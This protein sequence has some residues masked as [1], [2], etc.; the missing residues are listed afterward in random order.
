MLALIFQTALGQVWQN[1]IYNSA[2]I[3][4][5]CATLFSPSREIKEAAILIDGAKIRVVAPA[6]TLS[7]PKGAQ[8]VDAGALIAAPGLIDW[9]LNGGFGHDF[10]ENPASIWDVAARLPEHGVTSFL[11]TVIT[12]PLEKYA[13][14]QE[15]LRNGPPANFLGAQPLGLH[16][17]GPYLNPVRKGAHNALF[18]RAPSL[19]E[20]ENWS[21]KEGVW[22]VTLAPELPGAH[23]LIGSLRNKG[24]LVSVGHSLATYQEALEGFRA[25]VT[26]ATHLFNAMPALDHRAP[27]LIAALLN[28]ADVYVGLIPDGIHVHPAMLAL[29]WK[30][31]GPQHITIVTDAM[32]ALGMPPGVYGLGGYT[33]KV[34]QVSARLENGTLAGSIVRMD[35]AVRNLMKFTGCSLR[36]AV[37]AA[38]ANAAGLIGAKGKGRLCAGADA[39]LILMDEMANIM[40]T[41][42]R[43]ELVFSQR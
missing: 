36:Q 13:T 34:D 29:A 24:V 23:A 8:I 3:Y 20:T 12:A 11:P 22:L 14:A 37:A 26:C 33:V 15:V 30:L 21:R 7:P 28:S 43:G 38:S 17:E 19:T 41:Y 18:L 32:G 31:K 35:E 5:R 16:F 39:D 25:G 40:A 27:G 42:V 10:T 4:I 1:R 6:A 2:M 9:Q